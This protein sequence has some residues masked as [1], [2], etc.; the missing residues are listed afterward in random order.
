M[1]RIKTW[2]IEKL[3]AYVG[4]ILKGEKPADM[5]VQQA[6]KTR[7]VYQSQNSKSAWAYCSSR[8]GRTCRRD[9][10]IK[11]HVC[12]RAISRTSADVRVASEMRR[13][14]TFAPGEIDEYWPLVGHRRGRDLPDGRAVENPVQW[15]SQKYFA[16]PVGQIISTNSRRPTP[17]RGV[18]R[19][20]RTRGADAVDAAAFCVRGIAGQAS[21]CERSTARGR[22]M[23]LRTA[24]SCGPDAPTLASSSRMLCRP[25]RARIQRWFAGDGGKRARSPGRARNACEE[26]EEWLSN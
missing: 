11:G 7:L 18:S 23:L 3:G 9:D 22:E 5:P 1:V 16:S 8:L 20:S 21:A 6:T 15:A 13:M 4:R 17:Q 14:A 25:Y 2:V 26:K 12:S 10:R 19:S 24:K